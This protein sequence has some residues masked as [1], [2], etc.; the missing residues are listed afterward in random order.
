MQRGRPSSTNSLSYDL[1]ASEPIRRPHEEPLFLAFAVS[2]M[3]AYDE[4]RP[5]ARSKPWRR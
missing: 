4:T 2:H 3:R 5:L 1:S